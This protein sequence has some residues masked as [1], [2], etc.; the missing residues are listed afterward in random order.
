LTNHDRGAILAALSMDRLTRRD[1]LKGSLGALVVLAGCGPAAPATPSPSRV[2]RLGML[3]HA[4]NAE[5]EKPYLDSFR[6]GL[7]DLGYV[8]GQTITL[9]NRFPNEEPEKFR[10]MA[11]ELVAFK[12]D[13]LLASTTPAAAAV[14]QATRDIPIVFASV[15]DPVASEL[16][17][18][19]AKPGG[20]VTGLTNSAGQLSAKRLEYM[21]EAIPGLS[22]VALL[23]NPNAAITRRY[24]DESETAAASLGLAVQPIEART[25]DDLEPAFD[26]M[27][28]ARAEAVVLN[29]DGLFFQSRTSMP[30]MA[31]ARRLPLCAYSRETFEAGALLSYGP[32]QRLMFR[33][34]AVY[35]QKLLRGAKPAD[36]PVEQPTEFELLV[37]LKTAQELG[38]TIRQSVLARA[39]EVVE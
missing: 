3:W 13:V 32:D 24:L 9:E 29:P 19:L 36:L 10:A 26:R 22:R 35:V 11:A 1:W 34:A 8:E 31:L 5:E 30:G 39:T 15:P 4:A 33:R 23:V 7:R 28:E 25:L 38:L 12:P 17:D 21:K 16:V 37:N 6:Q 20:N 18:S 2:P 14:K 27:V